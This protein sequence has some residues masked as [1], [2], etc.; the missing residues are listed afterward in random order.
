MQR[1][2]L[3]RRYI[4]QGAVGVSAAA[5]MH[6]PANAAEFSYK[7]GSSSPMEHPAMARQQIAADR[8][9]K[10]MYTLQDDKLAT[11]NS[12]CVIAGVGFDFPY[13][14]HDWAA[15]DGN[16]DNC[17]RGLDEQTSYYCL[18]KGYDHGFHQITTRTEPSSFLDDQK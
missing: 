1:Q 11:Q 5:I 2:K 9:K 8:I 15:M 7:L 3:S 16:L 10:E 18:D 13:D 14:D 12:P 6:W 4:V 17:P